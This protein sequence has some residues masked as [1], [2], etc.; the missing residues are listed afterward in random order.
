MLRTGPLKGENM[1]KFYILIVLGLAFCSVSCS[2]KETASDPAYHLITAEEAAAMMEKEAAYIIVDVRR[3]DEFAEGHIPG[4]VNIPNE[5][6]GSE[7]P[8]ELPDPDMVLLVYCRTG[9]RSRQAAE[10]L[11]SLGYTRVYDFGGILS[12]KGEVER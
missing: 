9:R 2:R 7:R 8:S 3:P 1:R 6:I 10:K 5:E 4:A 12:W 11:L